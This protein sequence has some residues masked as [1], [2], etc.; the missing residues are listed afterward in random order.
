MSRKKKMNE[1]FKAMASID[2]ATLSAARDTEL[3]IR[4]LRDYAAVINDALKAS[5]SK[6]RMERPK[7]ERDEIAG[8]GLMLSTTLVLGDRSRWYFEFELDI[9][10][11]IISA[12]VTEPNRIS[13]A[14]VS[15]HPYH[16]MENVKKNWNI[17]IRDALP[18]EDRANLAAT[19]AGVRRPKLS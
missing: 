8:G 12:S 16:G 7:V 15:K 17:W 4:E 1:F 13:P 10:K 6:A 14:A 11:K 5:G 9:G 19:G 18:A 3:I 2:G